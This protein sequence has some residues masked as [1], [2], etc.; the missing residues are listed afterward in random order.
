MLI[1]FSVKNFLSFKDK[2]TLSME[3]GNGDENLDNVIY[4]GD[5][6]LLKTATVYGANASGKSNLLK[7]LTCAILMVRNSNLIPV[8]GKWNFIRPFLFDEIT[9]NKPS[10]F[11]FIFVTNNIKYR[12]FLVLILIKYMMKFWM[13]IIVKNQL[14]FLKELILIPMSLIMIKLN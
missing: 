12:Y 11:E 8:G 13:L 3:K 9:K 4:C 7:A 2:V 10:E 6:N 1:E 5:Y 14:I